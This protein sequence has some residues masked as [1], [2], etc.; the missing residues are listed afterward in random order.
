MKKVVWLI[1]KPRPG[2]HVQG[3]ALRYHEP[4]QYVSHKRK[5][6]PQRYWFTVHVMCYLSADW[7][8]KSS[9]KMSFYEQKLVAPKYRITTMSFQKP[10]YRGKTYMYC[11]CASSY[12]YMYMYINYD[13]H[14]NNNFLLA[15]IFVVQR[16]Q[17][18]KGGS[19]AVYNVLDPACDKRYIFKNNHLYM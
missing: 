5:I 7:Q 13:T 15:W 17:R 4:L 10:S 16:V 2:T 12:R 14:R 19:W 18:G 11:N 3:A 6:C 8:Q 9:A 1:E